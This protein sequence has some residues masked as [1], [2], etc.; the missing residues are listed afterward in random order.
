LPPGE[1]TISL[2]TVPKSRRFFEKACF[3]Q[4][5]QSIEYGMKP[6]DHV[7]HLH[8][9][10]R[11]LCKQF[12]KEAKVELRMRDLVVAEQ[13]VSIDVAAGRQPLPV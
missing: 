7:G 6:S 9:S 3:Q 1:W 2:S 8:E 11:Q 4:F 13:E 12:L 10:D 5:R